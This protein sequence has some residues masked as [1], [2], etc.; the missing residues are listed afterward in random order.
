MKN[1]L[2]TLKKEYNIDLN[3]LTKKIKEKAYLNISII[4]YYKVKNLIYFY[5]FNLKD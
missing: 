2:E 4:Y 5:N 1:T 3:Q